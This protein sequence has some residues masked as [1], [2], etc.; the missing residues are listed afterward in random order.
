MKVSADGYDYNVKYV[1]VNELNIYPKLVLFSL[2]KNED[3]MGL[4]RLVFV[5]ITGEFYKHKQLQCYL[6]YLLRFVNR[7]L[8]CWHNG[9]VDIR[10]CLLQ[11]KT[12]GVWTVVPV[13]F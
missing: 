5:F 8:S 9:V 11:T 4:P 12:D 3:V 7:L 1:D 6:P 2:T 13:G 10:L